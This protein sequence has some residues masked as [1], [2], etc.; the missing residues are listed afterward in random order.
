MKGTVMVTSAVLEVDGRIENGRIVLDDPPMWPEGTRLHLRVMMESDA[1]AEK[2]RLERLLALAGSCPDLER[3][4]QLEL[5]ERDW[6]DL[7]AR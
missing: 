3:P 4:P 1:K 7:F 2:E 5:E 6:H